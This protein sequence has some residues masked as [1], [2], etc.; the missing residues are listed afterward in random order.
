VFKDFILHD[1]NTIIQSFT[2][3]YR[4]LTE[5]MTPPCV[6]SILPPVERVGALGMKG[7]ATLETHLTCSPELKHLLLEEEAHVSVLLSVAAHSAPHLLG[8]SGVKPS[9]TSGIS[10][11][12]A[13]R[14]FWMYLL[15]LA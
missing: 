3:F 11:L 10:V 9:R 7:S 2:F 5:H 12:Y 14:V 13:S 4:A 8:P 6:T 15:S 1:F